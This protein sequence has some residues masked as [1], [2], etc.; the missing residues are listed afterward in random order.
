MKFI[1]KILGPFFNTFSGNVKY[2]VL[3]IDN[4]TQAI[5]MQISKK[6]KAF[7]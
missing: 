5:Q 4:L 2:S 7:P 3:N 6:R 1:C